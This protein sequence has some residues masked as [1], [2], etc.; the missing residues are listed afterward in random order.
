[1]TQSRALLIVP[2]MDGSGRLFD[3][4]I[5]RLRETGWRVLLIDHCDEAPWLSPSAS[6]EQ[7]A[8]RIATEMDAADIER[9]VICGESFG[10]TAALTFA[11]RWPERVTALVILSGFAWLPFPRRRTAFPVLYP[12]LA[13]LG[14]LVPVALLRTARRLWNPLLGKAER[15]V[16]RTAVRRMHV[17][18]TPCM[19]AK[20][21]LAVGFD[22]RPWLPGLA[23]PALIVTGAQDRV[24][25]TDCSRELATGIPS[26]TLIM[27]PEGGHLAHHAQAD[28]L[29]EQLEQLVTETG[30]SSHEYCQ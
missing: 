5:E 14:R 20:M 6:V 22:A 19:L 27:I 15:T 17:P 24:I 3:P 4:L 18:S 7:L 10:S 13:L 21:R 30:N 1:M 9:A 23:I 8:E 12:L 26:A 25:P 29:I 2:G 28:L 11:R 16:L